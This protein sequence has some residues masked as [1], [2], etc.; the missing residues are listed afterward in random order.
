MNELFSSYVRL[1]R[2]FDR[3]SKHM[4]MDLSLPFAYGH[5]IYVTNWVKD[6]SMI[7]RSRNVPFAQAG[8]RAANRSLCEFVAEHALFPIAR[9]KLVF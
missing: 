4:L 7:A 2:I 6:R 3:T 9:R 8:I 1:L 5:A